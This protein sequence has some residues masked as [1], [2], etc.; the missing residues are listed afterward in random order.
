MSWTLVTGGA[1]GLGASICKELAK[2]KRNL[3]VHYNKSAQEAAEVVT[4]CRALGVQADSLQGDFSTQEGVALFIQNYLS[5]FKQTSG[6]VNNIGNYL[7]KPLLST[8]QEE[9]SLLFQTNCFTGFSL[10]NALSDSLKQEQ[11]CVVTI[12][13]VSAN[14]DRIYAKAAAYG[15]TK[16]LLYQTLLVYAQELAPYQVRVN[17]VSP[18]YMEGTV[19]M[20]NIEQLPMKR[21]VTLDEVA[22]VVGFLFTPE[23]RYITGQNI[24]VSGGFGL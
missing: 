9:W 16:K 1:R 15:L 2:Q 10:L 5:L 20:C 23:T 13:S 18:G 17:M 11:G 22:K 3:V 24:D 19:D 8:T 7:K 21:L 14:S 4:A 6:L 12:G